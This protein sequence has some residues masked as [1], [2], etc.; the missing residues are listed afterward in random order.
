MILKRW[1]QL[2]D[3]LQMKGIYQI[4]HR[5]IVQEEETAVR[6][7]AAVRAVQPA[8]ALA[9]PVRSPAEETVLMPLAAVVT[10]AAVGIAAWTVASPAA[11]TA[12]E[13]VASPAAAANRPAYHAV[14]PFCRLSM[15]QWS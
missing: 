14:D 10:A 6:C 4:L 13:A 7:P 15:P 2:S 8:A 3:H 1:P 11:G 5:V 9:D 12:A